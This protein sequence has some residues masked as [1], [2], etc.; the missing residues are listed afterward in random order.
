VDKG[1]SVFPR[2]HS[3]VLQR[4]YAC[5][6]GDCKR[7]TGPPALRGR[8][9]WVEW[10]V[11]MRTPLTAEAIF[12]AM[13]DTKVLPIACEQ[14]YLLRHRSHCRYRRHPQG[15]PS[16]LVR[17]EHPTATQAI[18]D[19]SFGAR[20]GAATRVGR[21]ACGYRHT[22]RASK[23]SGMKGNRN[24]GLLAIALFKWFKGV[25]FLLLSFGFLKL[26]HRDLGGVVEGFAHNLRVDP[27]NRYL[28]AL[29][30]KL[31]LLDDKKLGA[32]SGLTFAYSAL[33]L[34][35]GTG[36]FFEKRWAEFLTIIATAS[37]MPL[38][39]YELFKNPSLVKALLLALN[40]GIVVFLIV[41]LRRAHRKCAGQ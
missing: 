8:A 28:S 20:P 16:V 21:F 4:R 40:A 38:E 30:A 17:S 32:L 13:A 33:F 26:L 37:F 27:D 2:V 18:G 5:A 24:K 1:I 34:T 11:S 39:F 6:E 23:S 3:G 14:K 22:K 10:W 19:L 9:G 7:K 25:V 36:L 12:L 31:S 15:S 35:E 41:S 29:L